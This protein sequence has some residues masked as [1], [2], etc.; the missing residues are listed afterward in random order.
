[1]FSQVLHNRYEIRR[2]LTQNT[3]QKTFLATNTL[4]GQ[5]VVIKI[6]NFYAEDIKQLKEKIN[7]IQ[8]LYS[9]SLHID[10]FEQEGIKGKQLAIVRPY[11]SIPSLA[12]LMND[13]RTFSEYELKQIAKYLLE[14]LVYLQ[15]QDPAISHNNLKPSNIFISYSSTDTID[16]LYAVDF[17]LDNP[18]TR[19]H[20]LYDIGTTLTNVATGANNFNPS[21]AQLQSKV[22]FSSYFV[23]WLK[24]SLDPQPEEKFTGLN[25][26]LESLYHEQLIL[27]LSGNKIKPYGSE[28]TL[29]KSSHFLQINLLS[30]ASQRVIN[31]LQTQLRLLLPLTLFS[32]PLLSIVAIDK[33]I[34]LIPL[35]LVIWSFL[36]NLTASWFTV[37]PDNILS[38]IEREIW[39]TTE[40]IG[41]SRYF[42]GFKLPV[43]KPSPTREIQRIERRNV[44]FITDAKT[45]PPKTLQPCLVIKMR[46]QEYRI[47]GGQNITEAELDW[48]SH[49]LSN[50]LGLPI[51][52][53]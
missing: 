23:Y 12:D 41:I 53:I 32:I 49:E 1:M 46:Q 50:W 30:K 34:N 29:Y 10:Y 15:Q 13:G 31:K 36:L 38:A 45:V 44:T 14:I 51:T 26:A 42:L 16:K 21:R 6:H 33:P 18:L 2:L 43:E 22:N 28:I 20:D 8:S 9:P 35:L 3:V 4:T 25:E 24:R 5:L 37:K 52:R 7:I 19:S 47:D 48:L 39:I 27:V 17:C 11:L 40:E